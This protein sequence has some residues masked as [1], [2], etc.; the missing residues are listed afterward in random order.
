M[1]QLTDIFAFLEIKP[2]FHV[3]YSQYVLP[4]E[5]KIPSRCYKL[6]PG[7]K[8]VMLSR[9]CS[10]QDSKIGAMRLAGES[11]V[12]MHIV[13]EGS[14]S[15]FTLLK[16]LPIRSQIVWESYTMRICLCYQSMKK[17]TKILSSFSIVYNSS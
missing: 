11:I 17:Y 10:D 2:A 16:L 14:V 7:T 12:K 5:R 3:C 1:S 15:R 13:E 9:F 6:S 8:V 4:Y